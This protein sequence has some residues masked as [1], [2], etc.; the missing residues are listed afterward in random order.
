MKRETLLTIAVAVLFLLNVG[1]LG[2]LWFGQTH[3]HPPPHGRPPIDAVL[4]EGL[5][6]TAEQDQ[7]LEALKHE[8]RE[9]MIALDKQYN[10]AVEEYFN[11]LKGDTVEITSRDSSE[12]KIGSIQVQRAQV[13]L[14]H[15]RQVKTMCNDEQ[16]KRFDSIIPKLV[17]IMIPPRFPRG[18]P[19]PHKF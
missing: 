4:M 6:L 3:H 18:G 9:S 1:T 2:F 7:K 14:E 13:T 15:F 10:A 5:Q 17:E 19:H 8:H 11:L 16:K 12:S